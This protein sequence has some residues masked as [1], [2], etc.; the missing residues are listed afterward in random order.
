MWPATAALARG[1]RRAA[2]LIGFAV[3]CL[4]L[5]AIADGL[6]GKPLYGTID[7]VL[8]VGVLFFAARSRGRVAEHV[9]FMGAVH[10]RVDRNLGAGKLWPDSI[11]LGPGRPA[12]EVEHFFAVLVWDDYHGFVV[13]RRFPI[14]AKKDGKVVGERTGV[15]WILDL[16]FG[17]EDGGREIELK[18][19][20]LWWPLPLNPNI[21]A[22]A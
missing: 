4:T 18:E 15:G 20:R 8:I 22:R 16:P 3:L 6:S 12:A 1:S 17:F 11:D 19:V 9:E 10:A 21:R 5:S 7:L 14:W 2:W 13:A